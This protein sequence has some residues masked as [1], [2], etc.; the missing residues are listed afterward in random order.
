MQDESHTTEAQE[1][2]ILTMLG[3]PPVLRGE[4]TKLVLEQAQ[5]L[6]AASA[7]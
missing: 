1:R 4:A 7:A 2:R 3:Y 5:L 6:C